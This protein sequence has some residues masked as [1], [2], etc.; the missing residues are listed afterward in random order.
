LA[1]G[2]GRAGTP[3]VLADLGAR[4]GFTVSIAATREADGEVVRSS[5]IHRVISEGD[6]SRAAALLGRRYRVEGRVVR[7]DG[8]GRSI[9]VPTANVAVA[10]QLLVPGHGVYAVN[11]FEGGHRWAGAANVGTRHTF[12]GVGRTLE[13]HLLD[14]A[15]DLY[16]KPCEVEFV[17][18]L[19]P[20]QR[21]GSVGDLVN[22]IHRDVEDAR[23]ILGGA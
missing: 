10:D 2:R 21:F 7:G 13:V 15:G 9:G 23:R 6:V 4:L 3:G 17:E 11:F 19:R 16:D 12:D 8:R 20:E 1:L 5:L 14:F 22:Q 18:R